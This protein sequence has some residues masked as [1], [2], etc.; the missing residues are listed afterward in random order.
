MPYTSGIVTCEERE[1]LTRIYL[2]ATEDSRKVS[3]SVGDVHGLN[4]GSNQGS[5]ASLQDSASSAKAPHPRAWVLNVRV[6][7]R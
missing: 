1:R 4:G 5:A 6:S 7:F 2:D 3:D